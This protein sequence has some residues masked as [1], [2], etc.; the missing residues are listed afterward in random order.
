MFSWTIDQQIYG[1]ASSPCER[2]KPKIIIGK[3]VFR[4]RILREHELRTFWR[5]TQ[6][7]GYPYGP[8]F[9][10]L[11]LTGQRKSE[12]AAAR[13]SEINL[14]RKLW[15]IPPDRMKSNSAHV[16]PLSNDVVAILRALPRFTK[17][18][19]LFSTTFGMKPVNG[20]SKA[21]QRVDKRIS[22][23]CGQLR[24]RGMK[25]LKRPLNLG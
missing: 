16:V 21:K 13:W 19:Y 18:D 6:R 17:G 15:T 7:L 14:D 11:A 24:E 8:L 2:L 25:G 12:V 23:A 1:L 3:K 22:V 20:F 4:S 9:Q 10:L 5:S